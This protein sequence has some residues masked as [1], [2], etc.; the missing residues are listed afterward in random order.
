MNVYIDSAIKTIN[1]PLY[2]DLCEKIIRNPQHSNSEVLAIKKMLLNNYF[3]STSNPFDNIELS[4][5]DYAAG[6]ILWVGFAAHPNPKIL[7]Q[8]SLTYLQADEYLN[9]LTIKMVNS[10]DQNPLKKEYSGVWK[11]FV[12]DLDKAI[13]L[14]V[15]KS[16]G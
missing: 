7:E 2:R 5:A 11:Q 14:Q 15:R 9:T 3:T 16:E 13:N 8:L 4:G 6:I 12:H 10:L 1:S